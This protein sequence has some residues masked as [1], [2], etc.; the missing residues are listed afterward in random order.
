MNQQ[1]NIEEG[2]TKSTKECF[3]NFGCKDM[4]RERLREQNRGS[5]MVLEGTGT[6]SHA[7]GKDQMERRG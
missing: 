4:E 6:F 1:K 5:E 3:G 2:Q 7:E